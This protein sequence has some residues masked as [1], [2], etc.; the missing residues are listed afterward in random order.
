M[1]HS[2]HMR[3]VSSVACCKSF[4]APLVMHAEPKISSSAARPASAT[5]ICAST[6]AA[7]SIIR[8]GGTAML[9]P[10]APRVEGII[11]TRES[12]LSG[13]SSSVASACPAS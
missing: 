13:S 5:P 6:C 8:S 11:D 7:V 2:M 1:P 3:A 9:Y 10:A 4:A 12:R